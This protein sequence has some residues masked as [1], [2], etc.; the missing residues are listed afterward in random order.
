MSENVRTVPPRRKYWRYLSFI[1]MLFVLPRSLM[2]WKQFAE[3]HQAFFIGRY[4][5]D[6]C[7]LTLGSHSSETQADYLAL[8]QLYYHDPAWLVLKYPLTLDLLL[9]ALIY[10]PLSRMDNKTFRQLRHGGRHISGPVLHTPKSFEKTVKGDGVSIGVAHPKLI[11][12]VVKRPRT[13]LHIPKES[14]TEHF[15]ISG[16]PGS[17]KTT[18][19]Q[20]LIDSAMERSRKSGRRLVC[21]F[22]DPHGS[23]IKRYYQPG[24]WV[25]NPYDARSFSWCPTWELDLN[26]ERWSKARALAMARSVYVGKHR[27]N[28]KNNSSEFFTRTSQLLFQQLVVNHQP[29]E[30]QELAFWMDNPNEEIDTR[31]TGKLRNDLDFGSTPQRNGIMSSFTM[32]QQAF[33][34]IPLSGWWK[35]DGTWHQNAPCWTARDW[36]LHRDRNIFLTS[37][38]DTIDALQPV[39]SM[40]LDIIF[41]QLISMGERPDVAD[42]LVVIDEADAAQRLPTLQK[43]ANQ[44]RKFNTRIILGFQSRSQLVDLY[45]EEEATAILAAMKTQIYHRTG[46]GKSAKWQSENIGEI[47][48]E[49]LHESW[50]AGLFSSN[51]HR[52][53]R[54]EIKRK[55]LFKPSDFMGLKDREAILRFENEVVKYRVALSP[56]RKVT[57]AFLPRPDAPV[58]KGIKRIVEKKEA[59]VSEPEAEDKPKVKKAGKRS[60][61]QTTEE[62]PAEVEPYSVVTPGMEAE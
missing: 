3:P 61:K 18:E 31:V 19:M 20:W 4:L 28:D 42:V 53:L 14:E 13:Y 8:Q 62:P 56:F 17:G 29:S 50:G 10:I 51:Q 23:F 1:V 60:K 15:A 6:A 33:E 55:F 22:F 34:A 5:K 21:V 49:E 45:G 11:E 9:F 57:D 24:D 40:W 54:T 7:L 59:P 44:I 41:R 27:E 48:Y 36:C 47:E 32:P 37:T 2:L 39:H 35:P 46:E 26:R 43:A 38:A 52:Q 58:M 16:A 25:G 30:S 12:T